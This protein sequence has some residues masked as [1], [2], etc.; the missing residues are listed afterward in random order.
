MPAL[1]T[2]LYA[3]LI[4]SVGAAAFFGVSRWRDQQ[5]FREVIAANI[6]APRETGAFVEELNSWVYNKEGFA[7][8]QARYVWDPLG[9]TPAQI[10][11]EG[12][13]CAD[14]SRLLSAMLESVGISSTLVMLQPCRE[15]AP[16]HTIVN[17]Y[18]DGDRIAA[19]PVYD[20]VF[21]DPGGGYYGVAEVR[22]EPDILQR[23]LAELQHLRGPDDKINFHDPDEMKY[24]FPKTVNWDRDPVF[25][26]AG[27][28]LA[29][30]TDEPFLVRRPH[31]LEDPKLILMWASLGLAAACGILLLLIRWRAR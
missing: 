14:K 4:L 15:C 6:E 16:T 10:F 9:A 13:D 12:G 29:T 28:A 31:L 11:A 23:R 18:L 3:L 27:A 24:G 21:P 17:A 20:L 5:M 1:R 7:Q 8:C 2:V 26:T 22:D 19:D 30:V 25:R